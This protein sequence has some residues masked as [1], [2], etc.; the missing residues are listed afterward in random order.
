MSMININR[1]N[2]LKDISNL[3]TFIAVVVIGALLVNAFVLRSY[4]VVGRSMEDT[5]HDGERII[6]NQLPKTWAQIQNID[7]LPE[8]GEIIVFQNA[9]GTHRDEERYIVKRVIAFAGE[10][11]V[12]KDGKITI[13]NDDNPDGFNPDES[14]KDQPRT[15]TSG[16]VDMI[17]PVKTIFV[18][19]DHRDGNNSLDSRNG[20]GTVPVYD[21]IGPVSIRWW[22]LNVFRFF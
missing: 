10:R 21:V 19:G 9:R 4:G 22:P 1:S 14:L 8:R 15:P 20:L 6:V 11:V 2:R 17:V 12:V 3:I 13:Y 5:M 16:D 7:Y 18:A